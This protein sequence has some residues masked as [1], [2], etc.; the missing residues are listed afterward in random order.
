[1]RTRLPL[2]P[3]LQQWEATH[4]VRVLQSIMVKVLDERK[5]G[6]SLRQTYQHLC[7]Q[8]GGSDAF[9][10]SSQHQFMLDVAKQSAQKAL[11]AV[12]LLDNAA[13]A[14]GLSLT[15]RASSELLSMDREGVAR[16]MMLDLAQS[17]RELREAENLVCSQIGF[18]EFLRSQD[19]KLTD[20]IKG[21]NPWVKVGENLMAAEA[22]KAK[23]V[24]VSRMVD[25]MHG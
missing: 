13:L 23:Q 15:V 21:E 7:N 9:Y 4:D 8:H 17:A 5:D 12:N 22:Y 24:D 18:L 19:R 2:I 3:E 6:E 10:R 25:G 16:R 1:M 11:D 14:N 20:I